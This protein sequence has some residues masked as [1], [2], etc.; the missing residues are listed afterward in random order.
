MPENIHF[1]PMGMDVLTKDE[2]TFLYVSNHGSNEKLGQHESVVKFEFDST[3]NKLTFIKDFQHDAQISIND[4]TVVGEDEYYYTN[5][6]GFPHN[7]LWRM[8]ELFLELDLGSLGYCKKGHCRT[9]M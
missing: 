7:S 2:K 6:S 3:E 9:I 4:L 8:P 1:T 5:D